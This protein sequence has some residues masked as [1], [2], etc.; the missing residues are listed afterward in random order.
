MQNLKNVSYHVAAG[1]IEKDLLH[2]IICAV[3]NEDDDNEELKLRI[4]NAIQDK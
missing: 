1:A 3:L 4:L 2:D